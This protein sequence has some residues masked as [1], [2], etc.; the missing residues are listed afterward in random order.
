MKAIVGASAAMALCCAIHLGVLAAVTGVVVWS[1]AGPLV[2]VAAVVAMWMFAR[3]RRHGRHD[4]A[5]D[6][7]P[8]DVEPG[9]RDLQHDVADRPFR[10]GRALA[11]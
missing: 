11:A 7:G 1:W 3:R 2:A 5:L 8:S 6:R 4:N 9:H 10:H